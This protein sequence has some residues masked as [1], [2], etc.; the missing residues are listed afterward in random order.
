MAEDIR[1]TG[2]V[3]LRGLR[4]V[5]Q[6][7]E[8]E[9]PTLEQLQAANKAFATGSVGPVPV[10]T[11]MQDYEGSMSQWG[12]SRYDDAIINS[13]MSEGEL[14]DT[15][16]ENQGWYDV[17][18]NGI[19]KMLGTAGTTFVSSLVGLPYGL[20]EAADQGRWSA[21]WDNDVTQGLSNVDKWLEENM[22]NY[23]SQ[24]QQNSPW[25]SPDNLFSMNFIADDVIK[26]AGFTLGAAAS[27]AVGS[28]SLGLMSKALGFAN[29][30]GKGTK[31]GMAALSSLFSATGE[32]MIE[33]K[34]GVEERN[35]LEM[36]KLEDS[37]AP[38][39]NALA[40]M[41][42]EATQRYQMTGDYETYKQDILNLQATKQ[43]LDAKKA[44]GT[45]QIEESGQK[46][47]NVILLANQALLT[48]GN[49]IQ[50]GKGAVK[51]F[52]SAR[53]AAEVT[54]KAAKP[55]GV[56][57]TKAGADLL[58][59]GYKITG[60]NFGRAV[61]AGKG[62]LTE[63]SEE[64]NQQWIQSGA[65]AYYNR[66]DVNDYWKA[67][68]DPEA[69]K[70]TTEGLYT[71]GKALDRGFQESWGDVN[72]WEQFVIGG[73]T[74]MAGSYSPT[75]LFNQDKT[76]GRLDPRRYG[77]WEGGAYNELKDFNQQYS[78]FE[79][80]VNE[81]NR[82]LQSEDFPERVMDMVGHTYTETSKTAAAEADDKKAYKDAEDKQF[83]HDIQAFLRAGKL[84]DLRAIYKETGSNLSDEDVQNIVQKTTKEISAEEDK[85]NHDR[86]MDERIALAESDAERDI[87]TAEKDAYVGKAYYEG[88]YVDKDGNQTVSNDEIRQIVKHN[89]EELNRKLD[90]Y[91]DSIDAVNRDTKG[92]LSKDQED[93]LAYLHNLGKE[94][95]VRAD[96]IIAEKRKQMPSKFLMKTDKTPEQL[97]KEYASSDL[98][99]NKD[100]DTKEGYVEV[101]TSLMDDR[102]FRN[103]FIGELLWGG[104]IDPEFGETADERAAREEEE[105][106]LSAEEKK[107]RAKERLSKKWKDALEKRKKDAEEQRDVNG[108][109]IAQYFEANYRKNNNANQTDVQQ[110]L[111]DFF[112]DI[113]DASQLV[114]QAGEY[115][116]TL[117][118]YMANPSKVDEDKAKEESKATKAGEE[119]QMK[120]KFEGKDARQMKQ[121]LADGTLDFDDFSDFADMDLSGDAPAPLA[122]AQQEAKKAQE[123]LQKA[124]S[125]KQHIQDQLGDNPTEQEIAEAQK[126]MQKID[127]AALEAEDAADINL[128]SPQILA[129]IVDDN[130]FASASIDD[131]ED[132]NQRV[133][134]RIAE[135][136]NAFEEDRNAQDDIPESVPSNAIE[137]VEPPT[138]GHDETTKTAPEVVA[139]EVS[140]PSKA[141]QNVVPKNPLTSG[142]I[143]EIIKET[144]SVTTQPNTNGTWRSTTTRHPYGKSTGTYHDTLSDKDSLQYKRSKAIW[145]YLNNE[146]AFDRQENAANDRIKA[147]DTIHFMVRYF[148]EVF[149]A[150]LE[151]VSD[152]DK[153]YAMAIIM[154]N[155]NGEV[156]GDLPLAELEP[157][158]RSDNPTQQVKDLKAMQDKMFKAFLNHYNQHGGHE[159]IVDGVLHKEGIDNLNLTFDNTRKSPLISRVKQVMRGVVPY[160]Y[161]EINTL[162]EVAQGTPE[163]AVKVTGTNVAVK[164]GDKTQHKDIVIPNVGTVGQPYL[165]LP[166]VS[167][168]KIAVPFYMPAFDAEQHRNTELYKQLTNA[169][170][171]MLTTN[172]NSKQDLEN[173]GKHMD[174]VEGLLQVKRQE[175]VNR[176]MKVD[177]KNNTVSLHLQ[178]LTNPEQKIDKVIPYSDDYSAMAKALA[179]SLSGIPINV[180]LQYL[181]D[182]IQTGIASGQIRK[183]SYNQLIGEI[184]NVNLPKATHHTV[185]SWFTVELTTQAGTKPSK[186]VNPK[187]TGKITSMVGGRNVEI[188]V[189]NL[190]AY[191]PNTGEIIEDN[192]EINLYLAQLKS[193]KPL[194]KGKDFIQITI[195]GDVRTYDVKNNKFTK[196]PSKPASNRRDFV[197]E[198]AA[199]KTIQELIAITQAYQKAQADGIISADDMV[200]LTGYAN[201]KRA[202]LHQVNPETPDVSDIAA[203]KAGAVSFDETPKE[204]KPKGK[205]IDEIENEAKQKKIV[206]RQTKDAW[207]AIPDNLKLKLFNKGASLVLKYNNI[208]YTVSLSNMGNF[209]R[210]LTDANMAAKAGKLEI[211]EAAKPME[212]EGSV[213]S[214]ENER[215][216]RRWL[217]KNLPSLSSEER[218]QFVDKLAR[219]GDNASKY[220]GSY[221]SGV[222]QI[223]RNAPMGTVYHEAFHYVMD[224]ILDHKEKNTILDIAKQEYGVSDGWTAEERLANDF[225]RYA[226]DENATG[227]VGR[228]KRWLRILKDKMARYNRISDATI[229]QLFWK[230]NNGELV[231]KSELVENFEETQQRV[232]MEIRNVQNEKMAWRNLP[233]DTK[234]ALKSFGLSEAVYSE[235]SLEEKEQYVK[236][237]G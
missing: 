17:L 49:L 68:M 48:A 70:D 231:E 16:Y 177:T 199:A 236:C 93:N 186:A 118:E 200:K 77:S 79:E 206:T 65:G 18:A 209:L 42:Q 119:Q 34:Q 25:Y 76:K 194:Y 202:L 109:L 51:S 64:M 192:E 84:D 153:P 217:A 184:A 94:S 196:N 99:F 5:N 191:D 173:F 101:D 222:I 137:D 112:K 41:Q 201:Q 203:P 45:Q 181:N 71:F 163:I 114:T 179:D 145:E 189:D 150:R 127:N 117:R 149:G 141:T 234:A 142:A 15:R 100:E 151:E 28:G 178:S 63:G 158:Y 55:F 69:T 135:A 60:K 95:L 225:R 132:E 62:L 113:V 131:V 4:G 226:M 139:P 230:I 144:D 167:G 229:T 98:V 33:A 211:T 12:N 10:D 124:N 92:A 122:D 74:G 193:Q 183:S 147:K 67:K 166:T 213:I 82:I 110:A 221:R 155:D 38:E 228:I 11:S 152:K 78:Q 31:I 27:M 66:E 195:G 148:P 198:I 175:G 83:V 88:A 126:A 157:S 219:M 218:T 59:T 86:M 90:S 220:W 223:Q 106:N 169:L 134:D 104:N 46:M 43:N 187:T 39:Y 107:K 96:K 214:R 188:D 105:K 35:K 3:G 224:M 154:L 40:T 172:G 80:N 146:H 9:L 8:E 162:N 97:T 143:V 210:I 61:A 232:L 204:V 159:A 2:P 108:D 36:Q 22:T 235:M 208:G 30:V 140:S 103:F 29:E 170:F 6:Q 13:P 168:E 20:F 205:T 72:Q 89:S 116:K 174:V 14:Q 233:S 37:L 160:R 81:V 53:H 164:R 227:I 87:L 207:A 138:T 161:G 171:Y 85:Q 19:G 216:A 197:K 133:L 91:L 26:N 237:R 21:L 136:M 24:V 180:S 73:L 102:S 120:N 7:Q 1:K 123:S 111:S 57:A 23:R 121:E 129:P 75:K 115:D 185:N 52:D 54:A 130:E 47:G 190:I 125:L 44:A 176:I 182:N 156:L 50:F 165:L 56:S 212:K 32:G 128:D 58:R 215:A